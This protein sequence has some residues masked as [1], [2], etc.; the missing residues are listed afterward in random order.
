M[1]YVLSPAV[2][3]TDNGVQFFARRLKTLKGLIPYE[4]IC[5]IRPDEPDRFIID[6][7]HHPVGLN[8]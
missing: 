1:N 2:C 3:W 8:A 7:H 4:Y 5:K 6:P